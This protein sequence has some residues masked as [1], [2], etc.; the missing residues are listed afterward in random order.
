MFYHVHD[1]SVYLGGQRGGEVPHR[2]NELEA[3]S[4]SFCPKCWSFKRS[5]SENVPLQ[6]R[7]EERVCE[8]RS[9]D[10]GPLPPSVYLGRH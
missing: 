8:M 10:G 6:V 9:F 3:L 7:N 5:R 1:V 2:K 4:C